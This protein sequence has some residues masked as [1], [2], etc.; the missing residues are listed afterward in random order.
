[1]NNRKTVRP[2]PGRRV[3]KPDGS[4]LATNGEAVNWTSYWLRRQRDGDIEVLAEQE[5]T[6]VPVAPQAE[7]APS[8]KPGKT[9]KDKGVA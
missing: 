9:V 2:L 3:R 7:A 6:A 8:T 4:L 5:E 1:M